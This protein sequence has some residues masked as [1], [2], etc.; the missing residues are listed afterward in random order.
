VQA[1]SGAEARERAELEDPDLVLSDV[2][3]PDTTGLELLEAL[4][5]GDPE[6]PVVMITAHGTVDTAVEAMKAGARDFLTKPLD[7]DKLKAVLD[8][9]LAERDRRHEVRR[10]DDR[11][12]DGAGLGRLIGTSRPMQRLYE[13]LRVL[14]ESEAS[15]I[16]TGE[17]GTGKELAA[18]TIHDLSARARGP[19]VAVNCAAIPETLVESE[20]F[21]HQ[22]GS[23]TGAIGTRQGCFEQADGGTLLLDEI[24]EMPVALQPKLLRV[25]EER[26]LRR[27]GGNREIAVDVRVLAATNRDP[28]RSVADG[29][30]REDLYY[31]LNVFTVE[32]PPLRRRLEDLPLLTQHFVRAANRRHRTSVEGLSDAALERL[33]SYRWPGNV[34]ELRNVVER[35][36]ILA[37]SGWLEN[38]HLPP[39]LAA[40]AAATAGD[41]QIVLP[42]NVTADQAERILILETL[43]RVENNKSR[44]A[45]QLGLDVKTIRNKLKA[46]GLMGDDGE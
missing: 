7:Y 12:E 11:L 22:A 2:V 44:A 29:K 6:R 35:G 41:E 43:K 34:R 19:F 17:S 33:R 20:L 40:P 16:L 37:Q 28:A 9:A 5:E 10:L 8:A 36:V 32:L 38:L 42:T 23:F 3:L 26:H 18:A 24:A 46:W 4:R 14:A 13:E 21:G 25:L 1:A 39:F 45:R 15:A 31:R 27:V 30:L